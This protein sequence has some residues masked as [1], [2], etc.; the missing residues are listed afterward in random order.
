M[1]GLVKARMG[2]ILPCT[3]ICQRLLFCMY[4]TPRIP[5]QAVLSITMNI[6]TAS[7]ASSCSEFRSVNSNSLLNILFL[8]D[9]GEG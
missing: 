1:L 6:H 4:N 7:S 9:V 3:S 8:A 2:C 5:G